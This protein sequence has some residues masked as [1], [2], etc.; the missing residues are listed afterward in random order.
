MEKPISDEA[1]MLLPHIHINGKQTSWDET[2]V[3]AISTTLGDHINSLQIHTNRYL[4][5]T[6]AHI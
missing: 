3:T 5:K 2:I 4:D 1:I 6:Y